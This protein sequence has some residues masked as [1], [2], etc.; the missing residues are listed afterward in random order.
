[1]GSRWKQTWWDKAP[2]WEYDLLRLLPPTDAQWVWSRA[3]KRASR[4]L[5]TRVWGPPLLIL[6]FLPLGVVA[7]AVWQLAAAAG[8][9]RGGRVLAELAVHLVVAVP[10]HLLLT[11]V[12]P[13]FMRPFIRDELFVYV[14]DVLPPANAQP[15]ADVLTGRT[16]APGCPETS[17]VGS[18]GGRNRGSRSPEHTAVTRQE[19]PEVPECLVTSRRS[20]SAKQSKNGR[21]SSR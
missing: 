16:A 15:W 18:A 21:Y 17:G 1:M 11:R 3:W 4:R 5:L 20:Q 9:G 10:F 14:R 2:G 13:P 8:W 7:V 6:M 12:L 19:L